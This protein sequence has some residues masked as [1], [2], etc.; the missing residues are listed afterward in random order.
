MKFS[1]TV[2]DGVFLIEIESKSDKRGYFER[3]Y[4]VEELKKF[5]I[6]FEIVQINRSMSIKAGTI[7]GLH[8]QVPPKSEDKLVQCVKG[9]IFDVALDV[10]PK[11]KTF[12]KWVGNVLSAKSKTMVLVPKG[13]A[14]GAQALEDNSIVEYPVSAFYSPKHERGFK[15][16]DP[17]FNI[18]WPIKKNV[19]VSEK[20]SNWP[21]FQYEK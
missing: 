16:N 17:F 15:W 10:R 4:D 7:R 1:K 6:N 14:H 20:D 3:V 11:S 13:V 18:D 19:V 12:G 21:L 9:S 8:M 5:G 2:I